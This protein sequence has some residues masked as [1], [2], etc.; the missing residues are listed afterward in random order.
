MIENI[1]KQISEKQNVVQ[2][3]KEFEQNYQKQHKEILSKQDFFEKIKI[4]DTQNK[5]T[6]EKDINEYSK[7]IE[8]HKINRL[9]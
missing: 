7:L 4:E 6:F 3:E 2:K 8:K 9:I 5:I 1:S